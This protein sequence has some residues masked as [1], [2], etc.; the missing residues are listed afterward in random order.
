MK[1]LI[2]IFFLTNSLLFSQEK[3]IREFV[4]ELN[5]K[6]L[7][8]TDNFKLSGNLLDSK[9]ECKNY[10]YS[11][12]EKDSTYFFS[13]KEDSNFI[14]FLPV[15]NYY[16]DENFKNISQKPESYYGSISPS[17]LLIYNKKADEFY[18]VK[19]LG[20][21]SSKY[22]KEGIEYDLYFE[23]YPPI[24]LLDNKLNPKYYFFDTEED[25]DINLAYYEILF[26]ENYFQI[27]SFA[28]MERKKINIQEL[29]FNDIKEVCTK[30]TVLIKK[31]YFRYNEIEVFNI[32]NQKIN[33]QFLPYFPRI[34][35]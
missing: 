1:R 32:Y 27:N 21:G 24:L 35:D 20:A 34:A 16:I 15:G 4:S 31:E 11:K 17:D 8:I 10:Y 18:Y 3:T 30:E 7:V 2:V 19:C 14:A 12:K 9:L 33:K 23:I 25:S 5:L 6:K 26:F 13:I 28:Q 29:K 22:S